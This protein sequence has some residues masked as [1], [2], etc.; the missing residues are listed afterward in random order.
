MDVYVFLKRSDLPSLKAWQQALQ[1]A[2]L[3]IDLDPAFDLAK[4]SGFVPNKLGELD[5]GFHYF[6]SPADEVVSSYPDLTQAAQPFD[7]VAIFSWGANLDECV[8]ALAA[9]AALAISSSGIMY[10]PQKGI[11]FEKDDALKYAHE[12]WEQVAGTVRSA[13]F[14]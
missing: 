14:E 6:L 2:D 11:L 9:A 8:A 7:T 13:R 4:N 1:D 10:D 5:T 12:V 3:P